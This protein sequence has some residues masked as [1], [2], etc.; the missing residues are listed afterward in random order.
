MHRSSESIAS[1]AAA[2]AKAQM[3]LTNPEK[4]LTGTLPGN[5]PDEPG[6]TFRYASLSAGLDIVRKVLG[7]HEIATLQTTMIDQDIQTVSL[8]T[9]LIHASGEWIASDWPVCTLSEM[10]TPR[11]MG[12]A[13]TYARRYGLFTLVGIAG[14][15]DLDA[16]DLAGQPA[17]GAAK[18]GN[19]LH[20]GKLNGGGAAKRS[21]AAGTLSAFANNRK[22]WT[23]PKQTLASEQSAALRDRLLVELSSLAS[24]DEATGWAQHAFGAKNTLRNVDATVVEAAFASRMAELNEVPLPSPPVSGQGLAEA[25]E[26]PGRAEL[27]AA[28]RASAGLDAAREAPLPANRRRRKPRPR[29]Q[30]AATPPQPAAPP[31]PELP[32]VNDAVHW[33]VDK[34]ALPLSEPRRYRDRAHL[35]F[36]ASQP[37]LLC[38]RQPCDAHHLRFMQPRALG[39]RVSDEF[40]VPLCRTHH[41]ALH[42]SGDEE[43]WWKVSGIDAVMIAQR[44]WQHSR[45][46]GAAI[47]RHIDPVLST[48]SMVGVMARTSAPTMNSKESGRTLQP[49]S[50]PT[51]RPA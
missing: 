48:T 4:S 30:V 19:V 22:P 16:P 8:T 3:A 51:G 5:R 31:L 47:Q 24:E 28:L 13:L 39:R 1:L 25:T 41:R 46:N 2:L 11:R 27:M 6:R 20:R 26:P 15:D 50:P 9:V 36:V 42:R 32:P 45:L 7:Q 38:G 44:L 21:A 23:P 17:D 18:V 14:E 12:A 43:A 33:H 10:A 37:C 34:S 40:A 49:D 29:E 35:E